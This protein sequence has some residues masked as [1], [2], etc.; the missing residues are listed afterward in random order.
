MACFVNPMTTKQGV[1][2]LQASMLKKYGVL[3]VS[4]IDAVKKKKTKNNPWKD[5]AIRKK[6]VAK[7]TMLYGGIGFQRDSVI[8]KATSQEARTKRAKTLMSTR[9][10]VSKSKIADVFFKELKK[11]DPNIKREVQVDKWNIDFYSPRFD[12]YVQFDGDFWHGYNHDTATLKTMGGFGCAILKTR[13]ADREQNKKIP[14]LIRVR[15]SWFKNNG[16]KLDA[17]FLDMV[18]S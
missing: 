13:K 8:R 14:N 1:K 10:K 4:Q 9:P 2:A 6:I 17:S 11:I 3:N 5:P 15:E 7:Q 12:V 18:H 16:R